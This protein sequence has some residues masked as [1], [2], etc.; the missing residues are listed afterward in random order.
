MTILLQR[1][2]F[3]KLLMLALS[4][5]LA[6]CTNLFTNPI[7]ESLKSDANANS[8]FYLNRVSQA[9]DLEDKQSYQLLA[10]RV[11]VN[12][13]KIAQAEAQLA[14]LKDLNDEQLLD[15]SLIEADI[16]AVKRE[17]QRA[18]AKLQ[19]INLSLLSS[20]Q[21]SRYYQTQARLA[22]NSNDIL[23]AVRARINMD[24]LIKD[25]QRKQENIDRTWALLRTANKGIINTDVSNEP[26]L[27]GWLAL[28]QTYNDN[29]SQPS[30]LTLA[31]QNWRNSYPNH[32]AAFQFPTELQSVLNFQ[33]TVGGNVGL[34]LPLS[35]D[36]QL[37]G[38]TIKAGFDDA[39]GTEGTAV[40]VFDSASTD[41]NSIVE[42]ANQS[43]ITSLVG[44]LLKPN[45]DTALS[46][47]AI[48]NFNVLA[49]NSTPT[50]KAMGKVCYYG[51]SPE[52]EAEDAAT[53]MWSDGI[54]KP[55][56]IV[57]QNDL[58]QRAASAFNVRWQQLSATD[59]VVKFYNE[60]DDIIYNLQDVIG[61]G[62]QALYVIVTQSEQLQG[63]KTAADNGNYGVKIY[64]SSR[65]NS[66]NNGPEFRLAMEGVIFSDIPFF[67][68]TTSAQ[69]KKVEAQ[70]SGNYQLMRLYAMGADAWLL[71][72][73]FNELRQV[74]G[75]TI[76]G[77]TGKLSAGPN[78]NIQRDMSWF[79]YQNGEIVAI[80]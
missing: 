23:A 10:A 70:T 75:Y 44:P 21:K 55:L 11:M 37:I 42:Q 69:Y 48:N 31:L 34:I 13:N 18:A 17:N 46:N 50:S 15:K 36:N 39:R 29:V 6:S 22:E 43:G 65:G 24:A 74:P 72:N 8:D 79:Q 32:S 5:F 16:A 51:L 33:P 60:V 2:D 76:S 45:V 38:T 28:T 73:R 14:E 26:T 9:K 67:T 59:S 19:T 66:A 57:P 27:A 78:C 71:S 35:G 80:N 64:A 12:E 47:A 40:Q 63:I 7:T 68:D 30:Q 62:T 25:T 4:L 77:L 41:V 56:V 54:R 49:L 3:R 1:I 53:K 61:Q 20:S 52:D 58:G